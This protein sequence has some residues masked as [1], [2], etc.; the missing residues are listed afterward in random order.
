M[1]FFHC[2]FFFYLG[3]LLK[4]NHIIIIVTIVAIDIMIH[5]L[6]IFT[7]QSVIL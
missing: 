1:I 5:L 3:L 2:D 4:L 7:Q 6:N